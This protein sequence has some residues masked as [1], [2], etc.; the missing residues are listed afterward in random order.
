MS[1]KPKFERLRE[2]VREQI[3][4]GVYGDG[5]PLPPEEELAA[6]HGVSR[7]T[8]RKALDSL[9]R[10]RIVASLR[11]SGTHVTLRREA[12]QGALETVVLVAPAYDPFFSAFVQ[13]FEEAGDRNGTL[14]VFKQE[15]P[16]AAMA[17]PEFYRPFLARGIRDFVLWPGRGFAGE[18]LLPRLRGLG[19]NLV[20]FDHFFPTEHADCVQLDNRHAIAALVEELRG[21]GCRR[22]D[23]L[24]WQ[25]VP[26]SS[27]AERE[28]AFREGAGPRDRVFRLAKQGDWAAELEGLLAGLRAR[29]E[30]P[31]GLVCVNAQLGRAAAE[32]LR[33]TPVRLAA[34]DAID[35]VPGAAVTCLAQPLKRMAEKV[36]ECL[37][38]Q[39]RLGARWRAGRHTLRGSLRRIE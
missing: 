26:L 31:D 6:R 25:D 11:G 5:D 13:H 1:D 30:L 35:P 7:V 29:R 12:F 19:S 8:V 24:G 22:L 38:D 14:V 36:F 21:R 28:A 37:Q 34:V 39:N 27:T 18:D 17:S 2:L 23:Y 10:E 9:K 15:R 32:Q 3:L 20:F 33:D 16:R 4:T